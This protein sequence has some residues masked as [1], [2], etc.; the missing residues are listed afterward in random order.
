VEQ[1]HFISDLFR[2]VKIGRLCL[3]STL[4]LPSPSLLKSYLLQKPDKSAKTL[5]C[6]LE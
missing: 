3:S 6:Y 1:E 2:Q 4:V 5:R